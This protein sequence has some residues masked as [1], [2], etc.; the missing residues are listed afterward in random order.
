MAKHARPDESFDGPGM[1]HYEEWSGKFWRK[2]SHPYY[3]SYA[4]VG[5]HGEWVTVATH[6][7]VWEF[8]EDMPVGS[9]VKT[10]GGFA[11]KIGYTEFN[12]WE[13]V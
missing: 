4:Y 5:E 1:V 12:S 2:E 7:N 6:A 8:F 9:V 10:V 13:W 11:R 3:T